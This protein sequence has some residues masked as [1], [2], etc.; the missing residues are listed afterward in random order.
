MPVT[1]PAAGASPSYR[2]QAASAL[3]SRKGVPDRSRRSMRSRASSLPRARCRADRLLAAAALDPPRRLRRVRRPALDCGRRSARTRPS[4]GRRDSHQHHCLIIGAPAKAIADRSR[5]G[6][7]R[8]C[9]R[10][11][12]TTRRVFRPGRRWRGVKDTQLLGEVGRTAEGSWS[13]SHG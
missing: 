4:V 7:W 13:T 9:R 3:S 11:R 5:H 1:M 8:R 2:P 12:N 6:W 10:S